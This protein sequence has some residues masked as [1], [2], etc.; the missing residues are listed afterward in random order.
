MPCEGRMPSCSENSS[1]S[2]RPSQKLGMEANTS[3][4]VVVPTSTAVPLRSAASTPMGMPSAAEKSTAKKA[5]VSVVGNFGMRMAVTS[6]CC[7]YD[8]P[9]S[10]CRAPAM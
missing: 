10:P 3:A 5:T 4:I 7:V 9:K 2:M 6:L 1:M 8:S